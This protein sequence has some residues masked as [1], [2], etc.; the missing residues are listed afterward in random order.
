MRT[1]EAAVIL[2]V[3]IAIGGLGAKIIYDKIV[4]AAEA[5]NACINN[6]HW[7][8][9]AKEFLA[10]EKDL[11]PGTAVTV[12]DVAPYVID[13]WRDCPAGGKYTMNPIG[14]DPTCSISGHFLPK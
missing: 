12:Q 8:S 4:G 14:K 6:L 1:R 2:G 13:G 11:R 7:I 3:T 5:R 10:R 9:G